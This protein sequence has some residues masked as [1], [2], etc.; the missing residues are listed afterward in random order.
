MEMPED[1]PIVAEAKAFDPDEYVNTAQLAERT[2][3]SC[4]SW[5]KRRMSGEGPAFIKIGRTVR[6]RWG[7]VIDWLESQSCYSTSEY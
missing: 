7:D 3:T 2:L 1:H 4:S 6:Y 5:A